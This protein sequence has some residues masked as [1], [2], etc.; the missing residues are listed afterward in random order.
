MIF[1]VNFSRLASLYLLA[2]LVA[3]CVPEAL[4]SAVPEAE[5]SGAGRGRC[6]RISQRKEWRAL[7]T[8]EKRAYHQAVLCLHATP[9]TNPLGGATSRFE[10]YIGVHVAIAP[11]IH[12]VGQFLPWHRHMVTLYSKDL[13]E[14]CNYNG[15]VPYWNWSIDADKPANIPV[16]SSVLFDAVTGFG[17][18]GVPG[19]YT[20]PGGE[21]FRPWNGKGCIADG[22]YK[23]MRL[24]I[25]PDWHI[26]EHCL[27]RGFNEARRGNMTTALVNNALAQP[28][29]A[30]LIR[31]VDLNNH[32]IHAGGH[33]FIGGEAGNTLSSPGDPL[34]YLH[35][36][37][38]DRVWWMW[39]RANPS[40]RLYQIAGFTTIENPVVPTTLDYVLDYPGISH[41]VTVR[42]VMDTS[43]EPSCYE[44]V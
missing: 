17:G 26:T 6:R 21:W 16:G 31:T 22:P 5:T 33:F 29:F 30:D 40:H 38:L 39:Q 8:R 3:V 36:A 2:L 42:D 34:F 44:Y 7:T 41:N 23:D 10:Q 27:A 14:Y 4:G 13:R 9:A 24:N 15:P 28:T 43:R 19:T 35:H 20:P 18:D 11:R 1:S 25:G 32:N 12:I 37:M